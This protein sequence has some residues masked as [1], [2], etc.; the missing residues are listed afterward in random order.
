MTTTNILTPKNGVWAVLILLLLTVIGVLIYLCTMVGQKIS[1]LLDMTMTLIGNMENTL[2]Q[3]NA[4]IVVANTT[5]EQAQTIMDGMDSSHRT[6]GSL[7]P[8]PSSYSPG[9]GRLG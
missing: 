1:P 8:N 3:V 9:I 6:V 5:L 7:S 2:K 4:T